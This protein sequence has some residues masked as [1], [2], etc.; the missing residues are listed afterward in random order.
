MDDCDCI[1][2]YVAPT[3]SLTLSDEAAFA[4]CL[5]DTERSRADRLRHA[6]ARRDF[7]IAHGLCRLALSQR[8]RDI[9]PSAWRFQ[10]GTHGKPEVDGSFGIRFN[11]THTEGLAAVAVAEQREVGVDAEFMAPE[12]A[13]PATAA[14]FCTSAELQALLAIKDDAERAKCFFALWTL[15]ESLLKA[16]GHGFFASPH[17]I[18]CRLDPFSVHRFGNDELGKWRIWAAEL[19]GLHKLAVSAALAARTPHL[20]ACRITSPSGVLDGK[21]R[22]GLDAQFSEVAFG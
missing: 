15:K 6:G 22:I 13:T 18:E 9:L 19:G 3:T 10:R 7:I 1:D 4:A 12:M 5:D 20:R 2:L 11:L 14:T 16:T 17:A 8:R 21:P